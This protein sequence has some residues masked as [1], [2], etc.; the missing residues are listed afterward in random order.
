M[1]YRKVVSLTNNEIKEIF[2]FVFDI[3]NTEIINRNK[4]KDTIICKFESVWG[5]DNLIEDKFE[6]SAYGIEDIGND[7]PLDHEQEEIIEKFL[8]LNV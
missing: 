3:D 8:I 7:Y 4:E 1:K 6:I 5:E 2:E